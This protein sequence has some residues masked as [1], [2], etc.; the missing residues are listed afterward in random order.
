ML[1]TGMTI[2]EIS[3]ALIYCKHKNGALCNLCPYAKWPGRCSTL[4]LDYAAQMLI[5][6]GH[7]VK[8]KE[9]TK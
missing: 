6:L 4:L 3:K 2:E 7:L 8:D 9:N 5:S 1:I